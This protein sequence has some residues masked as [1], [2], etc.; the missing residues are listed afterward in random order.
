MKWQP[1][2]SVDRVKEENPEERAAGRALI[3]EGK[4]TG[5]DVYLRQLSAGG[6]R[7]CEYPDHERLAGYIR[8]S[9]DPAPSDHAPGRPIAA[10]A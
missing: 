4:A 6:Q 8:Q 1:E 9:R 7:D 10:P 2:C 5:P 3:A